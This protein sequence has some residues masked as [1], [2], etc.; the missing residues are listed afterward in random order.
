MTI[1]NTNFCVELRL[2]DPRRN[3]NK[4]YRAILQSDGKT[5]IAQ[6]GRIGARAQTKVEDFRQFTTVAEQRY[7]AK[8]GEK[9]KKGYQ[10]YSSN[11][12]KY[13]SPTESNP[14][15]EQDSSIAQKLNSPKI[16]C[17]KIYFD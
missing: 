6:W 13:K 16:K 10:I 4:Y 9:L 8:I 2:V 15:I 7:H 11:D 17:R 12:P 14:I 3:H 5:F 1:T